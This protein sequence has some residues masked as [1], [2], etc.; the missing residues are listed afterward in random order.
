MTMVDQHSIRSSNMNNLVVDFG[1]G[2]YTPLQFGIINFW[3]NLQF[4]LTRVNAI[5]Y[6]LDPF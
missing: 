4:G 6:G 5:N 2:F 3:G 1:T